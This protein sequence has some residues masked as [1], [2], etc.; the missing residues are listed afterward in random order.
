MSTISI[1]ITSCSNE[2]ATLKVLRSYTTTSI[3]RLRQLIGTHEPA[4]I[5]STAEYPIEMDDEEGQRQ[6]QR[7]I[8]EACDRLEQTGAVLELGYAPSRSDPF[9]LIDRT[10][11]LN[12]F[13]SDIGYLRREHD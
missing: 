3:G 2:T 13:E 6:E 10:F 4:L 1:A 5:F 9:E 8:I 11:M 7:R 12:Q